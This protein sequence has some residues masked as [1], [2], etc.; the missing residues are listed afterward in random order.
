MEEK[1]MKQNKMGTW[2]IGKL[3]ISMAIPMMLSMLVQALYNVVDSMFVAQISQDKYELTAVG[4]AF[5]IQNLMIAF[6]TGLGVG[7]TTSISKNLGEGNRKRANRAAAQGLIVE[8]ASCL[9]FTL[10]GLFLVPA[11]MESQNASATVIDCGIKYLSICCIFSVGFFTQVAFEKLLQSTGKTLHSMI[12]Q[13]V[14]AIANIILDPI[15]IFG[16]LGAPKMGIEGAAVATVIG[17]FISAA[18]AMTLH[19]V[20]NKELRISLSDFKPH[21]KLLGRI[22]SI[23]IP[24]VLMMAI[25]SVMNYCMNAILLG[26]KKVGETAATVFSIYFKMQSFIIMPVVGLNNGM[27]P[28][29]SFNYGA[30]NKERII[31][32]IKL[33][34]IGAVCIMAVGIC[35]FQIA[36][37]LLLDMFDASGAMKDMGIV[38]LRIISLNFVFAGVCIVTSAVFQALGNGFFSMLVSFVRQIIV[39]VPAAYLLS[40]SGKVSLVWLSFPIAECASVALCIV[41]FMHLYKKH[42]K[43][44]GITEYVHNS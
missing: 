23:G 11:F 6:G 4:L 29:V 36:P 31:K 1:T 30:R 41:I 16:L 25:G 13:A 33:S 37:G 14:G 12:A 17:Q 3:L 7:I 43:P 9:I 39:L 21:A 27:I 35:I 32:T 40:L 34:V 10:V 38:A 18:T 24:S 28:I 44:L 20:C 5:P 8:L 19:F 42:I 26:M 22:L 15:F 2:P